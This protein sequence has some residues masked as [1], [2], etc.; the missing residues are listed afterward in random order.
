V[1]LVVSDTS[2]LRALHHLGEHWL[3]HR[4]YGQILVPPTVADELAGPRGTAAPVDVRSIPFISVRAPSEDL[5]VR[6]LGA[7]LD[8]GEAEAIALAIEVRA[9]AILI[10]ESAGRA[11]A[12][13]AGLNVVG[14]LGIL[15]RAKR[16]GLIPD[17]RSRLDRLRREVQFYISDRLYEGFLKSIDE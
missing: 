6:Q 9:D 11:E 13:R 7:T 16:E 5:R 14:V 8:R 3:L 4:F 17:V 15:G 1:T 10:D 12:A 2:P